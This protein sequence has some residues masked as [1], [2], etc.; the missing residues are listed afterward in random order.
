MLWI[1]TTGLLLLHLRKQVADHDDTSSSRM[2]PTAVEPTQYPPR[3]TE[4][5]EDFNTAPRPVTPRTGPEPI[6]SE[7]V[8]DNDAFSHCSTSPVSVV[9]DPHSPSGRHEIVPNFRPLQAPHGSFDP[10]VT[11]MVIHQVPENREL[12]EADTAQSPQF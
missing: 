3:R 2:Q 4:P 6:L 1:V 5:W 12:A 8:D 10:Y 9:E 11:G 7:S